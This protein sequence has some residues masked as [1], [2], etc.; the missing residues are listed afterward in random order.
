MKKKLKVLIIALIFLAALC[1]GGAL[2]WFKF[3]KAR[4]GQD[5]SDVEGGK[6]GVYTQSQNISE[7]KS[8]KEENPQ[9]KKESKEPE[10]PVVA[11]A[12]Q[13]RP[14]PVMPLEVNLFTSS[15]SAKSPLISDTFAPYG[16]LIK[17]RLVM[18]I[19]SS[20]LQTPVIAE[21]ME[22]VWHTNADGTRNMIIERGVE[23]HGSSQG[24]P[25][26]DRISTGND[27]VLVWRNADSPNVGKELS[28]K[29]IALE[30]SQEPDGNSYTITDGSAGIT[31]Y[32]I[33]GS[34]LKE[35]IALIST[36]VSGIGAG[37]V[38]S[39]TYTTSQGSTTTY[40]GNVKTAIALGVQRTAELYAQ[41]MLRKIA[42]DAIYVRAPAGTP[43]YLYVT[44][45]LDLSKASIAGTLADSAERDSRRSQVQAQ[46]QFQVRPNSNPQTIKQE[47]Q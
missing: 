32:A 45:P 21:V 9:I 1:L 14:Q 8:R 29:G 25:V 22:E 24:S 35:I 11:P 34:E 33:Q 38:Q 3:S 13:R 42:D 30:N 43:F 2:Y 17:C 15:A 47:R 37:L 20:R 26:R 12:P 36:F 16:R 18:T 46:P 6:S 23:V 44:Q 4:E 39:E 5:I 27:W 28:L 19:D 31:G 40:D 41:R 10:K 7:I